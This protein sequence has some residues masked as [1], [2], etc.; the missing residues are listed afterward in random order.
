M[1]FG[2]N[3]GASEAN[4]RIV[5][6]KYFKIYFVTTVLRFSG[7]A[8]ADD[9]KTFGGSEAWVREC[10]CCVDRLQSAPAPRTKACAPRLRL[11]MIAGFEA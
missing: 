7:K 3:T 11:K 5:K 9:W 1:A 2:D 6:E 8:S 10:G 4:V